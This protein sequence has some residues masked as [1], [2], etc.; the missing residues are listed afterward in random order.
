MY[1]KQDFTVLWV[2]LTPRELRQ[3]SLW[4]MEYPPAMAAGFVVLTTGQF[5]GERFRTVQADSFLC[6][7][8]EATGSAAEIPRHR[9]ASWHFVF[10]VRGMYVTEARNQDGL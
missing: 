5:F 3:T 10:V 4:A 1:N 8:G 9:H 6:A 7:E 2:W